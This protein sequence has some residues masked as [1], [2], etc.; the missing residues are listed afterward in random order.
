MQSAGSER[1]DEKIHEIKEPEGSDSV[2]GCD[3]V[4]WNVLGGKVEHKTEMQN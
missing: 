1:L 4:E 2:V 3:T